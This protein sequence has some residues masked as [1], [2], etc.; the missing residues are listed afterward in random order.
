MRPAKNVA[1]ARLRLVEENG[2][3]GDPPCL[4]SKGC[5][6]ETGAEAA[7]LEDS[8]GERKFGI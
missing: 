6:N 8:F 5:V 7:C 2:N 4:C 1:R 3:L